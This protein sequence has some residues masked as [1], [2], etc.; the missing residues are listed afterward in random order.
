MY[1]QPWTVRHP[2]LR[3][4]DFAQVWG[5]NAIKDQV[6]GKYHAYVSSM[7]NDCPL[8]HWGKNS[9]VD[10]AVAD[11]ITGPYVFQVN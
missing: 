3:V 7:T 2:T 11:N 1:P 4:F 10:H 9:R 8:S 6:T 5:G